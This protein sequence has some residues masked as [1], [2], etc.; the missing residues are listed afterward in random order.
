MS[1][2]IELFTTAPLLIAFTLLETNSYTVQ[3]LI[4]MDNFRLFLFDR[5]TK[6]IESELNREVVSIVIKIVFINWVMAAFIQFV[7]N[8]YQYALSQYE[9]QAEFFDSYFFIMTTVSTVGYGSSVVSPLGRIT[10]LIFIAI[11]V[12]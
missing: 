2:L 1:S 5:F 6:N 7:E 9:N 11:V 3:F 4:M 8:D 10:I 12:F